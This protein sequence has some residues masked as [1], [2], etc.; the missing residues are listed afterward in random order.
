MRNTLN[1]L[2]NGFIMTLLVLALIVSVSPIWVILPYIVLTVLAIKVYRAKD[3]L[4][5][6][7]VYGIGALSLLFGSFAAA[8]LVIGLSAMILAYNLIKRRTPGS[9]IGASLVVLSCFAPQV[10]V[11]LVMLGFIYGRTRR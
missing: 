8:P 4:G 10:T 5:M 2:Y 7:V 9:V 1:N 3:K 6:K 11:V